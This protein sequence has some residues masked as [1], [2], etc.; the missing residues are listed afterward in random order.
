MKRRYTDKSQIEF[1][2][3]KLKLEYERLIKEANA[4]EDA[5]TKL[6]Q[7]RGMIE[8]ATMKKQEAERLRTKAN[9]LITKRARKLSEK[10]AEIKTVPMPFIAEDASV[11]SLLE[12]KRAPMKGGG[13]E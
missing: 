3:D 8:D 11:S 9:N 7:V 12:E 13:G 5:A 2:I 10:L 1:E 4:L 6:F